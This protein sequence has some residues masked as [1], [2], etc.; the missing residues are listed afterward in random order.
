M[1]LATCISWAQSAA[2]F[3]RV[4]GLAVATTIMERRPNRANANGQVHGWKSILN[5]TLALTYGD[6]LGIS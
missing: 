3:G 5:T 4:R 6:R 2:D 1:A